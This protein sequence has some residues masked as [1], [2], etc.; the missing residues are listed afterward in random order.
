MREKVLETKQLEMAKVVS[1]LNSQIQKLDNIHSQQETAR[2]QLESIYESGEELDIFGITNYK[3]F[4]SKVINDAKIQETIIANTKTFLKLKQMEVNEAHKEVKI[5]E[6]L[7]EK[8]EKS[9]YQHYEYVQGKEIDDITS[10]R[11]QRVAG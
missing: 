1:V 9:F 8:Q 3:N 6:K 2:N 10:T 7:K 11:Y 5:L 4:L